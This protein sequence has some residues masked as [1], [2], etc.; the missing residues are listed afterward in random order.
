MGDWKNRLY[1]GDNL[2]ILRDHVADESVDL[3]YLDPPYNSNATY[4]ILFEEK[5]GEHS[6]S[7]IRA[8]DDTW[9]WGFESESAYH[10]V[11]TQGPKRLSDLLIALRGFLGQ[12]DMMAYLTMMSQRLVEM[13]RVLKN[14]GSIYLHCDPTA[15]HYLK[16][17]MDAV[18]GNEKFCNEIIWHYR[19][20]TNIQSRF[21]RMHDIILFYRKGETGTFNLTEVEPTRSQ[22]E[23]IERGWNVN[24]VKGKHGK[25]LQLLVYDRD[26]VDRAVKDGALDKDRYDRVVYRDMRMSAMSDT[27]TD[28][29]YLH[30][31]AKER[32][33]YPTQKPEALLER[34]I[35]AA[36]NRGDL[37]MDPF[38]GCGTALAAAERMGRRWTGIDSS[39]LAVDMT[40]KRLSDTFGSDLSQYEAIQVSGVN[41]GARKEAQQ[42]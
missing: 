14:T 7:R 40:G 23:V 18:F 29:Q 5:S 33:S 30:S 39:P 20:W 36:S 28:I 22:A 35:L 9:H 6:G 1:F 15:S 12:N 11:V 25:V 38:C 21:Q 8:F 13:H 17:I 19:R 4:N 24:K 2:D 37:V 32:L 16:L 10:E 41:S 3:I 31:Q 26:K 27:W 34:I 42:T